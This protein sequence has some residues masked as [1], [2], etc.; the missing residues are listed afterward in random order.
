MRRW[1][2]LGQEADTIDLSLETIAQT[3]QELAG[4][5]QDAQAGDVVGPV[6][7]DDPRG[8]SA[9]IV[10]RVLGTTPAGRGEFSDFQDMIVERLRSEGLTESVIEELRSQAYID[11][12]IG[13]G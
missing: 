7:V 11:I 8:E 3:S 10:G 4:A 2:I 6:R 13:G 9:W 12:R 5:M 1:R